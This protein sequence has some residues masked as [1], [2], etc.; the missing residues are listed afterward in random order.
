[1]QYVSELT[2][3]EKINSRSRNLLHKFLAMSAIPGSQ[4]RQLPRPLEFGDKSSQSLFDI[5][6]EWPR[7]FGDG[8]EVIGAGEDGKLKFFLECFYFSAHVRWVDVKWFRCL[9][10]VQLAR[11][12]GR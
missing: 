12:S 9:S 5:H 6:D 10:E 3:A 4:T 7:F 1:V 8:Y 2:S 11:N